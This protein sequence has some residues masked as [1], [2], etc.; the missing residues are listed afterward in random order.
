M[1]HGEMKITIPP[2]LQDKFKKLGGSIESELKDTGMISF[3]N[4]NQEAFARFQAYQD[5]FEDAFPEDIA[6]G[7]YTLIQNINNDVGA[8][9]S[10]ARATAVKSAGGVVRGMGLEGGIEYAANVLD[11]KIRNLTKGAGSDKGLSDSVK[12][13]VQEGLNF[14]SFGLAEKARNSFIKAE[15]ELADKKAA[16][17]RKEMGTPG[18]IRTTSLVEEVVGSRSTTTTNSNTP[19]NGTTNVVVS[20]RPSDN[21]S[22]ELQR[23]AMKNPELYRNITGQENINSYTNSQEMMG[24]S[25]V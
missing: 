16:Q 8:L 9:A 19:I 3:R 14:L 15:N 11:L 7:Q 18:K 21:L 1:A 13:K 6:R 22:N 17:Q 4:M 23:A 5:Q 24:L 10:I 2:D 25:Y 12:A 20:F